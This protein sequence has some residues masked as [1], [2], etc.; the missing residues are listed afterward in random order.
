MQV[1]RINFESISELSTNDK[2]YA[3]IH[4]ALK[5]F[6]KYAPKLESFQEIIQDKSQ[7]SVDRTL[8]VK[9]LKKQYAKLQASE[10]EHQINLLAEE[11]TY[12]VVTAHQPSLFTGPLYTIYKSI[13]CIKLSQVLKEAL[14]SFNF[15]PVFVTGGED[16]DFEEMNHLKLFGKEYKWESGEVGSV[17]RMQ[18]NKIKE[19]LNEIE[20]VLGESENAVS[21]KQYLQQS[22]TH[23]QYGTS[24]QELMA[25][26][27]G[28]YGLVV[29]NMDDKDLKQSFIPHIE[30]EIFSRPSQNFILKAQAD[31]EAAGFKAQAYP[32]PINF[33]YL[34]DGFRDRIIFEDNLYKIN[35]QSIQFTAD[36]LQLEIKNHPERFSP[37]VVMRPLYQEHS[38]PNLAYI[39]GGG[40][41][42]YWLERK[43]QFEHFGINF[44][45]LIRRN[46]VLWIDKGNSKN[47]DKLNFKISDL[48]KHEHDLVKLFL[49]SVATEDLDLKEEIKNLQSIYEKIQARALRINPGLE[50]S[51]IAESVKNVKQFENMES[52]LVKAEKQ[53]NEVALNK[54]SKLKEKLFPGQSLQ[55]RKHNFME[56]YLKHGREFFQTLLEELNPLQEGFIIF[57]EE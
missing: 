19:V 32:R 38:L 1:T 37:N 24:F 26:L 8:L 22:L 52:K 49:N 51:I 29:L 16:H 12:T 11:N 3:G 18:T 44:P 9:V 2:G 47:M 34:G 15:I 27:L 5:P 42:A 28:E 4:P 40:E 54:I 25:S 43:D 30:K 50:K 10:P 56:M 21:L 17:G 13:S 48:F 20:Q 31:I 35:N 23:E 57:K 53:K 41:I 45:M 55:E 7:E 6:Y 36:E 33:F 39:G 14:P 46:S